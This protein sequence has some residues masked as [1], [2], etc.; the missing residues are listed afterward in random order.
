M[1]KKTISKKDEHGRVRVSQ[2]TPEEKDILRE[3]MKKLDELAVKY[4]TPYHQREH[5]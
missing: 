1:E 3:I 4:S 5:A 2:M